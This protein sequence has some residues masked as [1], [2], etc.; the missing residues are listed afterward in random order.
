[1]KIWQCYDN[2]PQQQWS[3]NTADQHFSV[4]DSAECLDLH[5]GHVVDGA[6]TQT[7]QCS[8]GNTNQRWTTSASNVTTTPP[9]SSTQAQV[10]HPNGNTE[11][12]LEVYGN[13][14]NGSPIEMY[15]NSI[16]YSCREIIC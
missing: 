6:Y 14:A 4:A 15:V 13:I 5:D 1:M 11:K 9:T 2:L 3:Y 10:L 7:W 16:C 12:C 8:S